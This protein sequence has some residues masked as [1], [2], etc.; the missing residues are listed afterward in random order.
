MRTIVDSPEESSEI[1]H[2]L[3]LILTPF[4][5]IG[6]AFIMITYLKYNDLKKPGANFVFCQSLADFLFAIKFMATTIMYY[7]PSFNQTNP[8]IPFSNACRFLGVLGQFSG[9]ASCAWNFMMSLVVAVTVHRASTLNSHLRLR[10]IY[11]HIYV[12]TASVILVLIAIR[13]YG[14]SSDGCWIAG[15]NNPYRFVFLGPYTLYMLGSVT[16]L[17][18]VTYKVKFSAELHTVT[19]RSGSEKE[20]F[21][22][23]LNK[24]VL[25][26]VIFWSPVIA[27]RAI[28]FAGD[29]TSVFHQVILY[30]DVIGCALQGAA[31]SIV[32]VS[33]PQFKRLVKMKFAS[34]S[35]S[36]DGSNFQGA[37]NGISTKPLLRPEDKMLHPI[38][39]S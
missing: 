28:E 27:L 34:S 19:Q 11:C 26:F 8:D 7:Y 21:I 6:S 24:Y 32:W 12:W 2:Y 15:D 20:K 13:Q 35:S 30:L 38:P 10:K 37:F 5:L 29:T 18:Y 16:V 36:G 1:M 17:L 25:I 33:S 9:H 23:Q 39:P 3:Y 22:S 4:S 14:P 31:N